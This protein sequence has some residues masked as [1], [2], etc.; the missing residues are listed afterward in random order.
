MQTV[1]IYS[2][3]AAA[4]GACFSTL[5]APV[6]VSASLNGKSP[7]SRDGAWRS[8]RYRTRSAFA[9]TLHERHGSFGVIMADVKTEDTLV[10]IKPDSFWRGLNH[11]VEARLS[12]LGLTVVAECMFAGGANL[13][14]EKW[15]ELSPSW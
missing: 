7:S 3:T 1:M 2:K 12:T 6:I 4:G 10:I 9:L 11:Q 14:E 8:K 5:H 13:P 15:R